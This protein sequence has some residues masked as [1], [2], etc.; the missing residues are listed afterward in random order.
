MLEN[1]FPLVG[2]GFTMGSQSA[3]Q[4]RQNEATVLLLASV[5][6]RHTLN[7][8]LGVCQRVAC[9]LP[10]GMPWKDHLISV[11]WEGVMREG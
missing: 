3:M 6:K 9:W 1:V 8:V 5:F 10:V 11:R 4:G 7:M 2:R